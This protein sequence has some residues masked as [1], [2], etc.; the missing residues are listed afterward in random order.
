MTASVLAGGFAVSLHREGISADGLRMIGYILPAAIALAAIAALIAG[1][2]GAFI[3]GAT[4]VMVSVIACAVI[5]LVPKLS[6]ERTLKQLSLEAAAELRPGE[7]IAFFIL[8]EYAPVFYSQGRVACGIGDTDVLNALSEDVLA[9]ALR[10]EP[11][12]VVITTENWRG[13][14]ERDRRF[15]TQLLARQHD[16]LAL[17]VSL[18]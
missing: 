9:D 2:R 11:S 18:R 15:T 8:K 3:A 6:D 5:V 13:G 16:A 14:L 17:R 12:F 7:R 1:K 4:G 10:S